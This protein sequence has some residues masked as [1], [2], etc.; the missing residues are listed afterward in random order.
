[1]R[2]TLIT[3]VARH[4]ASNALTTVADQA[5][6]YNLTIATPQSS[7]SDTFV[8]E[9]QAG[10]RNNTPEPLAKGIIL[11]SLLVPTIKLTSFASSV[12]I[13]SLNAANARRAHSIGMVKAPRTAAPL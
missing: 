12:R 2:T 6:S 10:S 3:T 8:S 7:A 5:R 4:A 1:M 13:G 11:D 9:E